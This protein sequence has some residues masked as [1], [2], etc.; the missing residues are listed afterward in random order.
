MN[1]GAIFEAIML[2]CFGV[3]WPISIIKTL[4][5]KTVKGT[6]PV[7]YILVFVGYLSGSIYK[8]YY[9]K[10]SIIF[11]YLLNCITVGIQ[12]ILYFYYSHR[13]KNTEPPQ[14]L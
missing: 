2:I 8:F 5:S 1:S 6:T 11:L 13:E 10:D 14:W 4:K 3:S 9:N 12:I 7:F